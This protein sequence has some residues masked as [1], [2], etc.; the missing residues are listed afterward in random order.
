MK[1][2][3]SKRAEMRPAAVALAVAGVSLFAIGVNTSLLLGIGGSL[4]I[5]G[6]VAS[7]FEARLDRTKQLLLLAGVFLVTACV[8]W[9]WLGFNE[10]I[11]RSCI[12]EGDCVNRHQLNSLERLDQQ[13]FKYYD[14]W[15]DKSS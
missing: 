6:A 5:A 11:K 10:T 13:L 1:N 4:L 15:G 2:S 12:P 7:Y 3:N 8:A 14:N 9:I